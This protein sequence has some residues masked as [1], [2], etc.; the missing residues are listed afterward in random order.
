MLITL[1]A[2]RKKENE[3]RKFLAGVNGI[4]LD[5]SDEP[6]DITNLKG[7]QAAQDGFGIDQGLGFISLEG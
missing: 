1:K 5:A 6:D 7:F 4:D 3:D 2:I